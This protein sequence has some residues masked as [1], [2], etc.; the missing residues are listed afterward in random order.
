MNPQLLRNEKFGNLNFITQTSSFATVCLDKSV[1]EA[2]I[3]AWRDLVGEGFSLENKNY[4]FISYKQYG[5]AMVTSEKINE[6][7]YRTVLLRRFSRK[8]L[9][10]TCHIEQ[11]DQ[12]YV[13]NLRNLLVEYAYYIPYYVLYTTCTIYFLLF[14][15]Y[16]YLFCFVGSYNH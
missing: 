2:A 6:N 16:F 11:R 10:I 3:G 14:I 5:R 4:R 9:V 13:H 15:S 1:L 7:H 12:S 8:R